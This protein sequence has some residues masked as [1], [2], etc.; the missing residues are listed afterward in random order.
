M[1]FVYIAGSLFGLQVVLVA[2][3]LALRYLKASHR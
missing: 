1:A 3:S 2:I